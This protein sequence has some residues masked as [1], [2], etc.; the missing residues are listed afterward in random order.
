MSALNR[1]TSLAAIAVLVAAGL[2]AGVGLWLRSSD[3]LPVPEPEWR[4]RQIR[5]SL[6]V[7]N[8]SNRLVS[9]G[10]VR[11]F[12]PLPQTSHQ[13]VVALRASEPHSELT[14]SYGNRVLEFRPT[15]PPYGTKLISIE[16]D[17]ELTD[18]PIQ[19]D[20]PDP[21]GYLGSEPYI[22]TEDPAVQAIVRSL[23][24]DGKPVHMQAIFDWITA[25]VAD[26]GYTRDD[27]GAAYAARER[28]GDCTEFSYLFVALA[29]AHGMP[30][31]MM[32]GFVLADNDK[33][34]PQSYH[35]W[36]EVHDGA[37][38]RIA[39][40]YKGSLRPPPSQYFAFRVIGSEEAAP[41]GAS[42]R[43]LSSQPELEVRLR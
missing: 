22:E 4:P 37:R 25:N 9:D 15:V 24:A 8:K 36:A 39:D 33:I 1:S 14:D 27:L 2:V 43:F 29:R 32:G 6:A 19:L 41:L 17:L 23:A 42:E 3:I 31:R 11:V 7:R 16:V 18:T 13:R 21:D 28:D 26:S 12:S 35:N 34:R 40:P 38:W 20:L 30:A 10:E 5:Y